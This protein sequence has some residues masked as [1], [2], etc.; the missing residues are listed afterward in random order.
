[1]N[2]EKGGVEVVGNKLFYGIIFGIVVLFIGVF[3][4]MTSTEDKEGI[5]LAEKHYSDKAY[6]DLSAPTK[7]SLGKEQYSFN[8]PYTESKE[9][10]ESGEDVVVYYWSP[11]CSYCVEESP[12]VYEAVTEKLKEDKDFK[13]LQV[14]IL[15][16]PEVVD[17]DSVGLVGTP[18]LVKYSKGIKVSELIGANSGEDGKDLSMYK[19]F[20]DGELDDNDTN[21]TEEDKDEKKDKSKN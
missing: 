3:V 4:Y 20:L 15:E 13:F 9:L 7:D 10:I 21:E 12:K 2:L 8:V 11:T 18:Q 17:D 16:Y 19:K 1:M 5:A 6:E 14:N